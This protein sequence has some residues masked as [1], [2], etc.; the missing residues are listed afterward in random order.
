M[1]TQEH[2]LLLLEKNTAKNTTGTKLTKTT[3]T[4]VFNM[5]K[6]MKHCLPAFGNTRQVAQAAQLERL[7]QPY[8]TNLIFQTELDPW[9]FWCWPKYLHWKKIERLKINLACLPRVYVMTNL[10]FYIPEKFLRHLFCIDHT[11]Y[12]FNFGLYKPC[13]YG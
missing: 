8:I 1:I 9:F 12:F 4:T 6:W 5:T 7:F 3:T 2:S 10:Y 13:L 11:D